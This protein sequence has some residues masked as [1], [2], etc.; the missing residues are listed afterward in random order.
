MEHLPPMGWADVARRS[1]IDH[2]RDQLA[3]FEATTR[4]LAAGMWALGSLMSAG[5]I[6]LFTVIVT[7][8]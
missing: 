8:F 6:G 2:L 3:D 7:K 1:D 4:G 5:F